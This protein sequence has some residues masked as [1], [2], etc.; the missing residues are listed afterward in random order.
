[1]NKE[2]LSVMARQ[3]RNNVRRFCIEH[4]AEKWVHLF[5]DLYRSKE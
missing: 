4:I 2:R 3:A 1:M 5:D